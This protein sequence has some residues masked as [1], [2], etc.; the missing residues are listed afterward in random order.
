MNGTVS[1]AELAGAL[2]I[3]KQAAAKK[4]A[5]LPRTASDG[6]GGKRKGYAVRHLPEDMQEKVRLK[7]VT[8]EVEQEIKA[9]WQSTQAA[10][11]IKANTALAAERKRLAAEKNLA[12]FSSLPEAKQAVAY[13]RRDILAMRG[14]WVE[15]SGKGVK[16]GT[17]LFAAMYN[18]R[19]LQVP[20]KITATIKTLSW[21]TINR[22][23]N[24]YTKSGLLGL[25]PGYSSPRKEQTRLSSEQ[26]DFIISLISTRP[27]IRYEGIKLA[28]DARYRL[29]ESE[30]GRGVISRFV[31]RWKEENASLFL[32]LTNPDRWRNKHQFALGSASESVTRLNQVWEFDSTPADLLLKDGRYTI[33]GV[34]D[35]YTRRAKFFV[36]KTSNSGGVA[37]LLREAILDWGIV[38]TAKTDNGADYVSYRIVS[39]L[40]ALGIEQKL[41]P[42]FTPENKPHIERLFGSFTRSFEELMPGYIGHSVADRRDITAR[43]SFASRIMGRGEEIAVDMTAAELQR[44]CDRWVN[45][46]Y[47][48]RPH[49]ELKGKTPQQMAEEWGKEGGVVR[50]IENERALDILL[51]ENPSNKGIRTVNKNGVEVGGLHYISADL[52]ECGTKVKVKHGVKLGVIH[53]F[54]AETGAALCTAEAPEFTGI[55]RAEAGM[56]IKQR[57]KKILAEE[58][59]ELRKRAKKQAVE[60]IH[61]EILSWHEEKLTPQF[62]TTPSVPYSTPQ[63]EEAATAAGQ[64]ESARRERENALDEE[65]ALLLTIDEITPKAEQTE[66]TAVK[67][68]APLLRSDGDRYSLIREKIKNGVPPTEDDRT[69]L[70][71]YYKTVSGRMYLKLEGNLLTETRNQKVEAGVQELF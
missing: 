26:Q 48:Q 22:W 47:H 12:D 10:L 52:P 53:L 57:Q 68:S 46:I 16:E 64:E 17:I 39:V 54:D 20:A 18:E 21:P 60:E 5:G 69:F 45:A 14:E 7:L 24:A 51:A 40:E 65:A 37:A 4:V 13:A 56:R 34:I 63:L 19:L 3:S 31:K 8:A 25:V 61:E 42:P 23:N 50:R 27:H 43:S 70:T 49:S 28:L 15:A 41:C 6:R 38:E 55:D 29:A 1:I 62:E 58:A 35:V 33:I 59:K 11:S 67:T 71:A 2:G 66:Q 44:Y 30:I 36:C 9:Q 32:Y